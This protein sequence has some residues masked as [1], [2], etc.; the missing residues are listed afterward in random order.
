LRYG[1]PIQVGQTEALAISAGLQNEP[2]QRPSTSDLFGNL[3]NQIDGKI[4]EVQITEL[5][6][7]I[8]YAEILIT[9]GGK[10][11]RLDARPSDGIALALKQGARIRVGQQVIKEAGIENHST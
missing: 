5:R 7:T 1:L 11:I 8:F 9:C 3:L 4:D 10:Q 2:T 6:D